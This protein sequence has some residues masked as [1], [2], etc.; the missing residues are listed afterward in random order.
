MSLP[1]PDPLAGDPLGQRLAQLRLPYPTDHSAQFVVGQSPKAGTGPAARGRRTRRRRRAGGAGVGMAVLLAVNL[2]G[3]HLLAGYDRVLAAVPV[4]GPVTQAELELLGLTPALVQP[5]SVARTLDGITLSIVGSFADANRTTVFVRFGSAAQCLSRGGLFG[6]MYLTDQSGTTFPLLASDGCPH[7]SFGVT[8]APLP[9]AELVGSQ[10][11]VLHAMVTAQSNLHPFAAANATGSELKIPFTVAPGAN[12]SLNL[13]SAVTTAN[14]QYRI[15]GLTMTGS[16]LD[17]STTVQGQLINQLNACF[18][19]GGGRAGTAPPVPSYCNKSG[20]AYPGIYLIDPSGRRHFP[21]ASFTEND[22]GFFAQLA[23][24]GVL[25]QSAL[26][27]LSGPGEYRVVFIWDPSFGPEDGL[28]G[29]RGQY[30]VAQA[31][32][33]ISVP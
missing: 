18:P 12:Y 8:F 17:I 9:K 23:A 32:W 14:T 24:T 2:V 11:L 26:F 6:D 28:P 19:T 10:Q 33:S 20:E 22:A 31:S 25:K 5:Q 1:P 16:A 7:S 3:A 21:S 15:T 13:P 30:G 29:A 27:D 4:V